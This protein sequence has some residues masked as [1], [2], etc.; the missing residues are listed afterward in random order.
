ML[1]FFNVKCYDII[2]NACIKMM[3]NCWKKKTHVGVENT[4][5]TDNCTDLQQLLLY[6]RTHSNCEGHVT[7]MHKNNYSEAQYAEC[8][9]PIIFSLGEEGYIS[10]STRRSFMLTEEVI[11]AV[12]IAF[13]HHL[14]P[15]TGLYLSMYIFI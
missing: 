12:F 9:L 13:V 10:N 1:L 11:R 5:N 7:A 8:C 6:L 4:K 3:R 15:G 2:G 14:T